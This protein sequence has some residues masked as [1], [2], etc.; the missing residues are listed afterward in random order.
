VDGLTRIAVVSVSAS[1]LCGP[2]L[3]RRAKSGVMCG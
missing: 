2:Q 1:T 3:Q